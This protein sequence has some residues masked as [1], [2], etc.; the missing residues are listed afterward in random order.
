MA[1]ISAAAG[2]VRRDWM[3]APST[4]NSRSGPQRKGAQLRNCRADFWRF[5]FLSVAATRAPADL[6]NHFDAGSAA[7]PAVHTCGSNSD[8]SRFGRRRANGKLGRADFF[9]AA[10]LCAGILLVDVRPRVVADPDIRRLL[11]HC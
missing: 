1:N 7:Y 2:G 4:A 3:G 5:G 6:W 8:L 11:R 9:P 10:L